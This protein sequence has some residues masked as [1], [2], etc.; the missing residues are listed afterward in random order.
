ML[1]KKFVIEYREVMKEWDWEKNNA[2]EIYPN[3]VTKG[4]HKK[5]WWKCKICELEWEQRIDA[6][7]RGLGCPK[8]AN[9]YQTSFPEQAIYY[10]LKRLYSDVFNRYIIFQ[11]ESDIFLKKHNIAIEYDGFFWHNG[12][13]NFKKE[14]D[15]YNVF[16]NNKIRLIRIK[17]KKYKF[18]SQ[19]ADILI[20]T[21]EYKNLDNV[22]K[23][24]IEII[25]GILNLN[26]SIEI[27][28]DKDRIN[29][30]EQY[31]LQKKEN[32]FLKTNSDLIK[33]WNY[34]KNK[35]LNPEYFS[36]GSNKKVWWKC[37]KGHEWQESLHQRT[38]GTGCP[39]CSGKRV[40][41]GYNDLTAKAPN[42]VKE[43]NYE[44]NLEL[45][46]EMFTCGSSKKVWW[47][48]SKCGYEWRSSINHRAL[49]GRGCA[50]CSN[51]VLK[52][53]YN[54]LKTTNP[55]LVK[56]WDYNKNND[57]LPENFKKSSNKK[58]WWK[59][60]RCGYEWQNLISYRSKGSQCPICTKNIKTKNRL[61]TELIN[62][63]S[64]AK[65][66]PELVKEWN[67]KKNINLT[68]ED[69]V[70]HSN[71][72]VWWKCSK[73]HE[74]QQRIDARVRGTRCPYCTNQKILK[75]YNDLESQNPQLAKEWNYEK[76][77][78]LKPSKVGIGYGK[79][80]WWKGKCGHVWQSTVYSRNRGTGCPFCTRNSP[81]EIEQY[82]LEG[83]LIKTFN[84]INQARKETGISKISQVCLGRRKTAGGF[85]WKYKK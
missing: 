29:I 34:K 37:S 42:L 43:W 17:E 33:E 7:I 36:K 5:A 35:G 57:L 49:K 54:D 8:C 25:D 6:R 66:H 79:L 46:P 24:I 39:Y 4:S 82:D 11:K 51:F 61:K 63:D 55:E 80:V 59:C 1:S 18:D 32:S 83:N 28:I 13:D 10:Y 2:L 41:K 56:E 62:K 40:L 68:P 12:Y 85:I 81:K 31:L 73:G 74:W 26:Y 21:D 27:D 30:M 71:K 84:S 3:K 45:S 78:S 65:S 15:K 58:V 9:E 47:K 70:S 38:S 64:F 72:K 14:K 22:I 20:Y 53:G 16:K 50:V 67:Y 23:K 19:T 44:K 48:C 77:G 52:K 75:G 76:N 60:S 69:F